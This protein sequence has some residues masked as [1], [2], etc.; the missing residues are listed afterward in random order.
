MTQWKY[1]SCST[2]KSGCHQEINDA[3][4]CAIQGNLIRGLWRM[5]METEKGWLV[6]ILSKSKVKKWRKSKRVPEKHLL[7]LYRL[8]QDR[9]LCGSQQTVENSSRDGNT[10]PFIHLL[11]NLYA[12]QAATVRTGHGAMTGSK[13][14]KEYVKS[15]YPFYLNSTQSISWETLG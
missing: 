11:R 3:L 7:L 10:R 13:L 4:N 8:C 15:I 2:Y 12:G 6:I 1:P 5:K 9:W 14:G